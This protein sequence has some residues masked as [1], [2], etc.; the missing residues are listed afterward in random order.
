MTR[1]MTS[2]TQG[3]WILFSDLLGKIQA[4]CVFLVIGG[5]DNLVDN[6]PNS[7]EIRK[8]IVDHLH[9]L[10]ETRLIKVILTLEIPQPQGSSVENIS[11]LAVY[12]HQ[13]GQKR[14]L[15][16]DSMQ[17]S[18]PV[19]SLQLT[20]IQ[21]KRC[22]KVSFLQLPMVYTPGS[23]VYTREGKYFRAFVILELSGMDQTP[24]GTHDP[25]R[26]Q[27]WSI[28]HNGTYIC[29]RHHVFQVSFFLGQQ[30]MATLRYVPAGYLPDE[31]ARRKELVARGRL[32]WSMG[33]GSHHKAITKDDVSVSTHR[34][35]YPF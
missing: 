22:R 2:S 20:E 15:S 5:I 29:K 13:T 19:L 24:S 16:F 12:R 28:D 25:L 4:Q 35:A 14:T 34:E 11:S 32:Y 17:S 3:L 10:T 18:L 31:L 7:Q 27:A 30:D 1:D 26:V 21:E 33:S 8:D 23:I 6:G 9:V